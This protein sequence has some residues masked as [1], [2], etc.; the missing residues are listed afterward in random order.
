M[1]HLFTI[2]LL[3]GVAYGQT[4]DTFMIAKVKKISADT[5]AIV[6][7]YTNGM[8]FDFYAIANGKHIWKVGDH[9]RMQRAE[10]GRKNPFVIIYRDKK[11]VLKAYQPNQIRR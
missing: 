1:R 3:S 9:I 7:Q 2:L 4:I 10:P 11:Y 5:S 8:K 6:L